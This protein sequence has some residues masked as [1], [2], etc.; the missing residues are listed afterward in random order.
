MF[1]ED[2]LSDI[3]DEG[4][5]EIRGWFPRSWLCQGGKSSVSGVR[6][7]PQPN[8]EISEIPPHRPCHWAERTCSRHGSRHGIES[9]AL[10]DSSSVSAIP[11]MNFL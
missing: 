5:G 1:E 8:H 6:V 2:L 4:L 3:G 7:L 11:P 9:T 10:E